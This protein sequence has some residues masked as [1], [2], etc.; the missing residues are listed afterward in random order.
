MIKIKGFLSFPSGRKGITGFDRWHEIEKNMIRAY[1][2]ILIL[3]ITVA[4]RHDRSKGKIEQNAS[5][6]PMKE[7]NEISD[8]LPSWNDSESK[9]KVLDFVDLITDGSTTSFVKEEDR[10]AVFDNDGT[11]WAEQPVYTQF[12]FVIDRIKALAPQHPEWKQKQPFKAILEG[13]TGAL[14]AGGEKAIIE[15]LIATHTGMTTEEFARIVKEWIATA[16]H[17]R[18]NKPYTKCVYQPMLELIAYLKANGF[19]IFIVSGGGIEFMRPWSEQVYGIP[20]EQIIGSSIKTRY[21][22][23]NGKPVL[24]RLPEV[25][26]IDDKAGKPVGINEHTGRLPIAAFGNSDGD[27]QMLE[28][29]T[30]GRNRG[31]ALIVHHDDPERE[32]AYDRQSS[33]GRLDRGL[34]EA[35]RRGW[36]VVS[37][38]NDWKKIFPE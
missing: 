25:N 2:F 13:D 37:M 3:W 21:Q 38:K 28:W 12:L 30:A 29:T 22:V 27:F 18:L 16:R 11:L 34:D 36:T 31:F 32:W 5:F 4:G 9:R 17:P 6:A 15:L 14:K 7:E 35:A 23:R 26:F 8:P 20:P 24:I 19:K 10:I 1:L 33:V